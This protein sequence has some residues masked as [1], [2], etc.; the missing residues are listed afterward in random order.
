M[1][2]T[3]TSSVPS[4]KLVADIVSTEHPVAIQTAVPW[5]PSRMADGTRIA[6]PG[7]WSQQMRY[8]TSAFT[9]D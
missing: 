9:H 4:R 2:M 8:L 5:K 3:M 1:K 6:P 7:S